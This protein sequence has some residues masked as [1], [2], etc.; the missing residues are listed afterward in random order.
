[1]SADTELFLFGALLCHGSSLVLWMGVRVRPW[2]AHCMFLALAAIEGRIE[3][4]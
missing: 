3:R 1:M 2:V 4:F